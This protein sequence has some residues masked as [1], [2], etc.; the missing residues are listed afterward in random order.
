MKIA[1]QQAIDRRMMTHG[2]AL[3]K[4]LGKAGEYPY[5][6]VLCRDGS[7]SRVHQS[8]RSRR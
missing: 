4:E 1:Q 8:R 2:I 7:I 3:S 5:A 6:A